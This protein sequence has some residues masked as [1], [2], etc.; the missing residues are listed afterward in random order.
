MV[1]E[2]CK[3]GRRPP[4]LSDR[5]WVWQFALT[6]EMPIVGTAVFRPRVVHWSF[7]FP[8]PKTHASGY[9]IH[10][11]RGQPPR[12]YRRAIREG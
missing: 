6:A 3:G 9:P 2:D 8:R 1:I 12:V 4:R 11:W 7:G 5:Y 10:P